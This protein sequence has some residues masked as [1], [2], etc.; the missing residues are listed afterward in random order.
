MKDEASKKKDIKLTN[1]KGSK[2]FTYNVNMIIQ[3]VAED[4]ASAKDKL[5]RE[6]GYVTKRD[7]YLVDMVSLYSGKDNEVVIKAEKEDKKK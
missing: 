5:D 1:V 4:E 7:V 6:G 3:V 2:C